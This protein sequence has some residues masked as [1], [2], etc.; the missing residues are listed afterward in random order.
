[1][2]KSFD[3]KNFKCFEHLKIDNL[4]RVNLIAGKNN[5][6]KTA[7]LEALYIHTGAYNPGLAIVL[8]S[9]RGHEHIKPESILEARSFWGLLFTG[10]DTT[11]EIELVAGEVSREPRSLHL[12]LVRQPD[13][14]SAMPSEERITIDDYSNVYVR[15]RPMVLELEYNQAGNHGKH[16]LVPRDGHPEVQPPPPLPPFRATFLLA[17]KGADH[18]K[19]A[20]MFGKLRRKSGHPPLVQA[21]KIL[22]P[23]LADL[24]VI[25]GDAGDMIHGDIGLRETMALADMGGGMV[26][27]ASLLLAIAD[28][29]EGAVFIDEIENGLHYSVLED[30]WRAIGEAARQFNVQVFA[31]T[32]SRECVGAATEAFKESKSNELAFYRLVWVDGK[33][34]ATRYDSESLSDAIE[35]GWEVR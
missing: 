11:K 3:I 10:F 32:H 4:A 9:F 27:L 24:T 16:W 28:V 19:H 6:G 26:R 17:R 5:V 34:D 22:E 35:T 8:K 31:T 25:P 12:R 13:D 18:A 21:L 7:L 20:G 23:R 15:G 2:Y 1:M 14:V 33:I 30:V 29:S